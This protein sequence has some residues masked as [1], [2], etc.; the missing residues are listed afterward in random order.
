MSDELFGGR[1][2]QAWRKRVNRRGFLKGA[3]ALGVSAAAITAPRVIVPA[4]AQ[5]AVKV[6]FWTAF[7]D[8]DLAVLKNMV[9]TY[10]GTAQGHQVELVQIPPAEVTD[11]TKLMTA[12]RG[13]TG[14]DVYHL[15]RFIVAQRAADQLL[16]DLSGYMGGADLKST[17]LAFAAAEA[18]FDGKPYAMPFDTDARALYYNKA[19]IQQAGIDPAELD[20]AKGPITWA[21]LTEIANALNV[22]DSAGNYSQMGFIP[23]VNQGWHYTYG[24]SYGGTF[25]DEASCQVTPDNPQVVAA[26]QWVYDYCKALGPQQ[27]SAFGT[28]T[29]QPGFP[30]QQHPFIVGTLAMQITGDWMIKQMAQYAPN[31][32]YGITFIPVPAAGDAPSTWAG[33]WS[34]VMPQGAKQPEEA[35]Q[36]MQWFAGEEGQRI[37]ATETA[38]LP[39]I[40]TLLEDASIYDE[41]HRFFSE[42]LLPIA[43]NRPPLPVGAKYWDELTQAW[44]KT[45]LNEEE[46]ATAL[47]TVKERV[48]G[49][50][51][52]FCPVTTG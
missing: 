13:G 36:F 28:P 51:Q 50:L 46:P 7:T 6:T 47:A 32:D 19:M 27:V 2:D 31:T 26:F 3:A 16:Q 41:R 39:T 37:Y 4:R 12:V 35:I 42:Q 24:F 43:K 8:P 15:D 40:L 21:R 29:M 38:H 14:P 52:R 17:H 23:W 5:D 1:V 11:V 49:D 33:G 34:V 18:S 20:A 48:Q 10:N 9:T 30:A 45:Y 44:Q 25:F 22:K